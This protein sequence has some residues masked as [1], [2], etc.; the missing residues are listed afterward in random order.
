MNCNYV[1][2]HGIIN[3]FSRL[4]SYCKN[5]I[6]RM[7]I[8]THIYA[9]CVYHTHTN[10][11]FYVKFYVIQC[12]IIQADS[13]TILVSCLFNKNLMFSVLMELSKQHRDFLSVKRFI[14]SGVWILK[15]KPNI[16]TTHKCIVQVWKWIIAIMLKEKGTSRTSIPFTPMKSV[17][18]P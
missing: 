18:L 1:I 3:S 13:H 11:S 5:H 4:F 17:Q 16:K 14:L 10:E 12:L 6:F 9:V 8:S 15:T 2:Q 7:E